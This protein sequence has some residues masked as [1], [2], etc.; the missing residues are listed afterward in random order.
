MGA[1]NG[2]PLFNGDRV[3]VCEDGKA[4]ET[5]RMWLH[6]VNVLGLMGFDTSMGKFHIVYVVVVVHLLSHV[7]LFA[8]S[9][10]AAHQASLSFTVS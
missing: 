10:A 9:W 4:L 3:S 1:G 8:T 2:K 5:E 6:T 7:Q